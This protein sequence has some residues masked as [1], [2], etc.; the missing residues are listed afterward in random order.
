MESMFNLAGIIIIVFGVLQI[1]LF[2]KI[3]GMTN[4]IKEIRNKYINSTSL[5]F[6]ET[7]KQ[8]NEDSFFNVGDIVTYKKTGDKFKIDSIDDNGLYKCSSVT[9]NTKYI[10]DKKSIEK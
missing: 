9:G 8:N 7:N 1:I 4:D 3:W 6:H 2:F 5:Q 10:L